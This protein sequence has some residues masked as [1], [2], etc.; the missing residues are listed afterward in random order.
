ME[1][2]ASLSAIKYIA[3]SMVVQPGDRLMAEEAH[4][5]PWFNVDMEEEEDTFGRIK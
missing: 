2:D 1:N 5:A 3:G 4:E